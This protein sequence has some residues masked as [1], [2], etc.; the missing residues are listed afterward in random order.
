ML[1]RWAGKHPAGASLGLRLG[2]IG[3][4]VLLA[5]V[6]LVWGIDLGRRVLGLAA[7]QGAASASAPMLKLQQALTSVELERD[8]LLEAQAGD[9]KLKTAQASQIKA[10]EVENSKLVED[11]ALLAGAPAVRLPALRRAEATLAAPDKL[12]Y[13]LLLTMGAGAPLQAAT[14]QLVLTLERD[15]KTSQFSVPEVD[16]SYPALAVGAGPVQRFEG[17][18]TVPAGATVKAVEA[19]LLVKGQAHGNWPVSMKEAAHVRS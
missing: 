18:L 8:Q 13:R 9:S 12:H 4:S 7:G 6:L 16:A 19:R 2:A 15:G 17:E 5:G 10:L 14:L 3:L 11:L 1:R